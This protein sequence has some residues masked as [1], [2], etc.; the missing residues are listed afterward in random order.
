MQYNAIKH[1]TII[2]PSYRLFKLNCNKHTNINNLLINTNFGIIISI[3]VTTGLSIV[4]KPL[5]DMLW[6]SKYIV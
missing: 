5:I 2:V 6:F 4:I 1:N 3:F